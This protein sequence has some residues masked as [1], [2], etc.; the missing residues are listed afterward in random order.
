MYARM[1]AHTHEVSQAAS[2]LSCSLAHAR[3]RTHACTHVRSRDQRQGSAT[4]GT[5]MCTRSYN[6]IIVYIGGYIG[7][8]AYVADWLRAW[9]TLAML[10]LWIVGGCEFE[11]RTQFRVFIVQPDNWYGFLIR[12]SSQILNLFRMLFS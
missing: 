3:T 5:Y 2:R 11:H 8:T 1:H 9:H 12:I 7:G 10:K 6:Y 4:G